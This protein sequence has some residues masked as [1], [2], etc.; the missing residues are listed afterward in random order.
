MTQYTDPHIGV[1]KEA[2]NVAMKRRLTALEADYVNAHLGVWKEGDAVGLAG[3]KREAAE[4]EAETRS[5]YGPE[6]SSKTSY[7]TT[8]S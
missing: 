3:S 8:G 1:W 6:H 5:V 4:A 7:A 2:M